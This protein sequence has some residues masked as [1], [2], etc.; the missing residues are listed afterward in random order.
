MKRKRRVHSIVFL[1]AIAI[2]P[3]IIFYIVN[4]K[5]IE[6]E[7]KGPSTYPSEW[8]WIQRT[9]PYYKT[10]VNAQLD[11]IQ[12]AKSLTT[13]YKLKSL[14]KRSLNRVWE[15]AGPVNIGGRVVDIEFNP[16]NPQIVYAAAATGGVYKSFDGGNTWQAIFDDQS[17]LTIGDIGIDPVNPNI[18]YVGTGE[19]N[20]G[21]NNFPGIGLYK[22]E[23][24][25]QTWKHIGL[26]K[27]SHIGRI[28]VAPNNSN[29]IFV[30]AIGSYF[31]NNSHRGIYRSNDAGATWD[32]V[33]FISDSTGGIDLVMD[34]TNP[35]FL[36]A[37][38][39]ERQRSAERPSET[40]L[41]GASGGIFKSTDGGNNWGK[42]SFTQGL[43]NSKNEQVGRIGL[44]MCT[45]EPNVI[46]AIYNDGT[47]VTGIYKTEDYGESWKQVSNIHSHGF[48]WYF[49]QIRVHPENPNIVFA[50]D[51]ELFRSA[52]GGN[53]WQALYD[54]DLHVDHHALT[55]HPN[56]ADIILSGND[57]GIN[58]SNNSG[59]TWQ[60]SPFLP[61]TQFYEIG[62]DYSNPERL[63]GGTQD[64]NTIRTVTG[65]IDD[66]ESIYG[67]D[68]FYVIVDPTNPNIIYCEAQ[69]G[70]LGKSV[71]GGFS[72]NAARNGIDLNDPFNW[73]TPIV[74]DP[75]NSNV[76]YLG[77]NKLYKTTNGA[78]NWAPISSIL[79]GSQDDTYLNTITTIAVAPT[80]S[81]KIYLGTASG[82]VWLFKS[83]SNQWT[84]ITRSLPKRWVTRVVVDPKDENT[85]YVTFSGLKWV[86]PQPHVFV[87]SNAG[88]T[89]ENISA[90]LPDA[91]VNAFAV[92]NNNSNIL[93]LGSDVGAFVSFNKGQSWEILA[94]GLP[95]VSVYDMK[96]H[97]TDNY[98]AIGTHGRGMYKISLN[99]FLDIDE[100]MYSNILEDFKLYQNFPNP[101][102]SQTNIKYEIAEA[103]N[104]KLNVY[105][106]LGEKVNEIVNKYQNPG[107]YEVSWNGKNTSGDDVTS[108]IYFYRLQVG[109]TI[110]VMKMNLVR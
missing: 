47:D 43:P 21:H 89:W 30:A 92:D 22:S 14:Q 55:F 50:M 70:Y 8:A 5:N 83:R 37:A 36:L 67:G 9:F 64:N 77:T 54:N 84:E 39:W 80:N 42:I 17:S 16:Q 60:R 96:I 104:I 81:Q 53:T 27:T 28:L 15:F 100:D 108:G 35:D 71:D 33:L 76:L 34:P 106:T 51:V 29:K 32:N 56:N 93:Y 90:N 49:G 10:N 25:G 41:Y 7:Q 75:N 62:L 19:P 4:H 26:E 13:E 94:D 52:D 99:Q 58:L 101:F 82:M 78:E 69:W 18:I 86:D 110:K 31:E 74:M 38:M 97:P 68:G 6:K 11:A 98:L 88:Q 66:W 87:S 63:Y 105:N 2:L 20:G 57:G 85:V 73:S 103:G 12:Q 72:F 23:D 44:S 1:L 91:P 109:N 59:S 65:N 45:A 3:I 61:V 40:Q 48:S 102:N 107:L 79:T 46:Y 24:A 95:V